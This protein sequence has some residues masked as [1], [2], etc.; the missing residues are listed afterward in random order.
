VHVVYNGIRLDGFEPRQ[1]TPRQP[2]IG[3]LAR[4]CEAK[5]LDDLVEAFVLLQRRDAMKDVRLSVAGSMTSTDEPFVERLKERLRGAGIESKA[6]FRPNVSREEKLEFLQDISVL[7]VPATYG[8]SFG[9]YLIEAWAAGIPVVQPRHAVFPELIELTGAGLLHEP[10]DPSS[11][12]D[13]LEEL[14]SDQ[15]RLLDMGRLGRRAVERH[16][17]AEAMARGVMRVFAAASD[18]Q[19]VA[20]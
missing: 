10:D 11:L 19:A 8:E 17:T 1:T 6:V 4:M 15:T 18:H 2:V 3:Y 5:G 20:G 9:L 16:F 7:S 12:A 13:R 14:L